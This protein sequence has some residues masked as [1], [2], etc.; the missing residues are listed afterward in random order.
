[1]RLASPLTKEDEMFGSKRLLQQI[2]ENTE[3]IMSTTGAGLAA[4]QTFA[5]TT[6][7]AFV[8]QQTADLAA[9][10]TSI[11]AAI[12]ALASSASSEDAAVQAAVANLN[13]ALATVESNETA[14]EALNTALTGAETPAAAAK[15]E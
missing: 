7:P 12:A 14:L 4:L 8:T 11:N 15:K 5:N 10:T 9:L 6:F 1:M 13:T 3:K 2:L